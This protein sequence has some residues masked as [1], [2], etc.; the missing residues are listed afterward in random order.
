MQKKVTAD[1]EK[2]G[3]SIGSLN[4]QYHSPFSLYRVSVEYVTSVSSEEDT[5]SKA[6]G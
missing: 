6:S 2:C 1:F 4:K 5:D 3:L